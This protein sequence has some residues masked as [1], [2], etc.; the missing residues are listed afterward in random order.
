MR[1]RFDVSGVLPILSLPCSVAVQR[2]A[3]TDYSNI[4]F[5]INGGGCNVYATDGQVWLR[6]VLPVT[7]IDGEGRVCVSAFDLI[8]ALRNLDGGEVAMTFSGDTVT[9]DYKNGHF[10]LPYTDGEDYPMPIMGEDV[11]YSRDIPCESVV[12]GIDA[13]SYALANDVLRPIMNC[14]HFDFFEDK[15]VSVATDGKKMCRLVNDEI[16]GEPFNLSVDQKPSSILCGVLKALCENS[17]SVRLDFRERVYTFSNARFS[18]VCTT[19][20]NKYPNYNSV[21]PKEDGLMCRIE[22]LALISALKRVMPMCN[23]GSELVLLDFDS[24]VVSVEAEDIDFRRSARENV[25][26]EYGG[27][28]MAI[29]FKSSSL[30]QTLQNFSEEFINI[31]FT[32]P[33]RAVLFYDNDKNEC[34]SL[35]MPLRLE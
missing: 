3:V 30:L 5:V 12:R 26:C 23:T 17:D 9:C 4:L 13:V 34:L 6:V 28:R 20:G 29:G 35:L 14:V 31:E 25:L 27:E 32:S 21:I 19:V 16:K 7:S 2:A 8:R 18:L 15:M 1:I 22:R 33:S 11:S 10:S 24:G